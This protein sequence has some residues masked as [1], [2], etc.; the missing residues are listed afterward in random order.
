MAT[1]MQWMA[2]LVK[3]DCKWAVLTGTMYVRF[4]IALRSA[5]TLIKY[6]LDDD[7]ECHDPM[8][9]STRSCPFLPGQ[10]V[11]L[12]E[13]PIQKDCVTI[14]SASPLRH[15]F[16]MD[17][18]ARFVSPKRSM[19][20]SPPRTGSDKSITLHTKPAIRRE[21]SLRH[22]LL[23]NIPKFSLARSRSLPVRRCTTAIPFS[24]ANIQHQ[25][26]R[27]FTENDTAILQ[28]DW[29]AYANSVL[30]DQLSVNNV[31]SQTLF[32][33]HD[34]QDDFKPVHSSESLSSRILNI[35]LYD[36]GLHDSTPA[37]PRCMSMEDVHEQSQP[38]TTQDSTISVVG[39]EDPT[40]TSDRTSGVFSLLSDSIIGSPF[41]TNR[42]S[43]FHAQ[44]QTPSLDFDG[45]VLEPLHLDLNNL[46]NTTTT[47]NS[48]THT[49]LQLDS[50]SQPA[51]ESSST[52]TLRQSTTTFKDLNHTAK[53]SPLEKLD[54]VESWRHG[55]SSSTVPEH[56]PSAL[57]DLINDLGYLSSLID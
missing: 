17:P 28:D 55:E 48:T 22:T 38:H 51:K 4:V 40:L 23:S 16:T 10:E 20:P 43:L 3:E 44:P 12:L 29:S 35:D 27:P 8:V 36:T 53:L 24:R 31:A 32:Y 6:R 33:P 37:R 56:E 5:N 2:L 39:Y 45:F 47:K 19:S 1:L 13:V 14:G 30:D 21:S 15:V 25:Q 52:V 41:T 57:Q 49:P 42:H 11:N 9:N 50:C 34:Q 7:A 54:M 18:T 26:I 46:D